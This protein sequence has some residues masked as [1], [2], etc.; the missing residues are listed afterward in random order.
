MEP[1][2][3]K[4]TSTSPVKPANAIK[5]AEQQ[6]SKTPA[7]PYPEYSILEDGYAGKFKTQILDQPGRDRLYTGW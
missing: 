3:G 6:H 4:G 7:L 2:R 5:K 1:V